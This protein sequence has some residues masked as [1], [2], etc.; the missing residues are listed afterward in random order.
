MLRRQD[1]WCRTII[2]LPK[3]HNFS[4][5]YSMW[6]NSLILISH[7]MEVF[8]LYMRLASH[9]APSVWHTYCSLC[10]LRVPYPAPPVPSLL[11]PQNQGSDITG[12]TTVHDSSAVLQA[13]TSNLLL[14]WH[15]KFLWWN[16]TTPDV[17]KAVQN[18]KMGLKCVRT[19][20]WC[21]LSTLKGIWPYCTC[22][23][24]PTLTKCQNTYIVASDP[25][26]KASDLILHC[27]SDV[28]ML[29]LL[30]YP[31]F[32]GECTYVSL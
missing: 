2:S 8:H 25:P 32:A 12:S 15:S 19:S 5:Q 24:P 16:W 13:K 28:S 3:V 30:P 7:S 4:M 20:S 29:Y 26:W 14:S 1:S 21:C 23:W 10:N 31:V 18:L 22:R 9:E 17:L 6:F 27:A 11:L